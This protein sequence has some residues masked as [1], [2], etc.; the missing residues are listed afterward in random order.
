VVG[1][2]WHQRQQRGIIADQE[3]WNRVRQIGEFYTTAD[4]TAAMAFLRK[5]DVRYIV[6]GQLERNY[7]P[8]EGLSKFERMVLEGSLQKVY[9]DGSTAIYL[10]VAGH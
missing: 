2:N 4:D 8:A 9:T 7:Y 5:Y 1:W 6:V 10:V 3:V